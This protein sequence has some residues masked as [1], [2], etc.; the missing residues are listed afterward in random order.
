MDDVSKMRFYNGIPC[1]FVVSHVEDRFSP[2][3][4]GFATG[5]FGVGGL[6]ATG[7]SDVERVLVNG[8]IKLTDFDIVLSSSSTGDIRI[9]YSKV[10]RCEKSS[11]VGS[12]VFLV[13]GEK[14]EFTPQDFGIFDFIEEKINRF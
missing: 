6:F 12:G 4:C 2:I 9:P 1:R 13:S 14:I 11:I 10:V 8:F 5:M 3:E 7:G